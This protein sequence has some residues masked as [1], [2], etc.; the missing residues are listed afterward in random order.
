MGIDQLAS[1][2]NKAISKWIATRAR[3]MGF[4][5]HDIEDVQ[6]Q[7]MLVLMDF[8]FDP[9]RTNGAS[10]QTVITSVIDR[11]LRKLKRSKN[12][13]GEHVAGSEDLP[14]DV[15]DDSFGAEATTHVN[16]AQDIAIARSQLTEF[17]QLICDA[18]AQG[19]SINEIAKNMD[20]NWHTV[21]KHVAKIRE[22]F[23]SVGLDSFQA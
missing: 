10:E 9:E 15:E 18:L 12:R 7:I 4:K 13:Y 16:M 19:L 23:Q 2:S 5:R 22:R 3:R 14:S 20:I 11:Q 8:Q 1:T 6:Q 17:E 21:N